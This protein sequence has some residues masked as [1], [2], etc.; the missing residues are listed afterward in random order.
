MFECKLQ[1][2][3]SRANFE[4]C[5]TSTTLRQSA[6]TSPVRRSTEYQNYDKI[7]KQI[8]LIN[9][10]I[11]TRPTIPTVEETRLGLSDGY[12]FDG[13]SYAKLATLK[14]YSKVSIRITL[15][16]FAPDGVILYNG[17]TSQGDGD[18]IA[19][20]LKNSFVELRFN[21]GSGSVVLKSPSPI[22]LGKSF[23]IEVNRHLSEA[24]LSVDL[25]DNV[26]GKSEG[27]HKLLDLGD[28]LFVGGTPYSNVKKISSVLAMRK[29]FTGCIGS[30][31][32]N[33]QAISLENDALE[34]SA[35]IVKS[36]TCDTKG[37][38][39]LFC[40]NDATCELEDSRFICS[41]H[42][43]F[44]GLQCE[45]KQCS[46]Q[47]CHGKEALKFFGRV[48]AKI[49]IPCR[50]IQRWFNFGL[51]EQFLHSTSDTGQR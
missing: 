41:C 42:D 16:A 47:K 24:H 5:R 22:Q 46:K 36:G 43:E 2:H 37:C 10:L 38:S 51:L 27:P 31:V 50:W 18:Y 9:E 15:T 12:L 11:N 19:I 21:L 28:N 13:D 35:K 34:D 48:I 8:S 29:N 14:A 1:K 45:S 20:L 33:Q 17:Q 26:T 30:F 49:F 23:V 32:V 39:E 40:K 6:T 44:T 7:T 4:K 25:Q 3:L